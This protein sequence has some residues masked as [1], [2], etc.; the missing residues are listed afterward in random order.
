MK[1]QNKKQLED[2]EPVPV[3]KNWRT[4]YVLVLSILGGLILIFY[5]ITKTFQ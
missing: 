5:I 3:F 1:D 4:W 2:T